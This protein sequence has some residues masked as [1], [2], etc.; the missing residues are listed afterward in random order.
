[1]RVQL[2]PDRGRQQGP[3][4]DPGDR[5]RAHRAGHR[6][7]AHPVGTHRGRCNPDRL[8]T[9]S[10]CG[11]KGVHMR[12]ADEERFREFA[13]GTAA[14]LRRSAYLLCGDWHLADDLVQT[15]LIKMHRA[16]PRVT[17][18]ERPISYA[19]K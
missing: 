12:K 10:S 6:A 8:R 19:R 15:T 14:M 4:G 7:T 1:H 3:A 13:R 17:R 16:W 9:V 11:A 2:R 5:R 18:T